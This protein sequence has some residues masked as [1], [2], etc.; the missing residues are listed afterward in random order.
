ML[1]HTCLS[2]AYPSITKPLL[3]SYKSPSF[4]LISAYHSLLID[5]LTDHPPCLLISLL[6]P[7]SY[8]LI[9]LLIDRLQSPYCSLTNPLQILLTPLLS[10]FVTLCFPHVYKV[11]WSSQ[12]PRWNPPLN[13]TTLSLSQL[14]SLSLPPFF[15]SCRLQYS[16]LFKSI[17]SKSFP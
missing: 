5:L 12:E 1:T 15:E 2:L 16:S 7:Y 4:W 9:Q 14:V 11:P 17:K 8:V 6:I 10:V 3:F 13:R